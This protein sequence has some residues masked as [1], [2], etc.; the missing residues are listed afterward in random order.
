MAILGSF[1]TDLLQS[2]TFWLFDVAPID[3]FG[4]PLF[5][6]ILGFSRITAPE[7]TATV[8]RFSEGNLP[9]ERKVIVG[10]STSTMTLERGSR[11]YDADFY[12]WVMAA[13]YG[14][15]FDNT[16]GSLQGP[17][18]RRDLVLIHFFPRGP[19]NNKTVNAAIGITGLAGA[20]ALAEDQLGTLGSIAGGLSIAASIAAFSASTLSS[21]S[22]VFRIPAKAFL[23][24]GCIPV[25]YKPASD[26]DA[27]STAISLQELDIE[28]EDWDEIGLA[29]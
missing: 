2:H 27:T 3:A 16:I 14:T 8:K 24:K 17:T 9:I 22:G 25:R 12:R 20:G 10:G 13:L 11:F 28:Y 5:T 4:L 7:V 15:G 19:A 23:L 26:F 1:F 18:I 29:S 6:P 21:E